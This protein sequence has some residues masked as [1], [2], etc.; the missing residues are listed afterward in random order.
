MPGKPTDRADKSTLRR[1]PLQARSRRRFEA[2]VEAAAQIFAEV[3]FE[4]ATT[5]AIAAKAQTSIG[6]VYQFFP[7]KLAIFE[8]VAA[9]CL[10]RS[11]QLVAG[12]FAT[13]HEDHLWAELV[14][15]AID[16]MWAYHR[17]DPAIRAIL[18]N[19][20]LYGTFAKADQELMQEFIAHTREI[21]LAKSRGLSRGR[22]TL[23]ASMVVNVIAALLLVCEREDEKQ[24]RKMIA[25]TK[26]LLRRY[27]EG[28]Q[29]FIS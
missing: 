14:D 17:S 12:L 11:R 26:V 29:I 13:W 28:E 16:G 3:G 27:L 22:A 23:L 10:D 21:L 18:R 15:A 9:H 20:H 2:I 7:S 19:L 6:S 1:Q 8:A 5:E 24:A 4:A 25:E